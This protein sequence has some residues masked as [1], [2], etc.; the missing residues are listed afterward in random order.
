M[1]HEN[2]REVLLQ[3][4]LRLTYFGISGKLKTFGFRLSEMFY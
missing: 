2:K 1:E 3:V 4:R